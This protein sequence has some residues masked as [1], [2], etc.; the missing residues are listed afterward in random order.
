MS[1]ERIWFDT[2]QACERV[3]QHPVTVRKAAESGEL[4]GS[5]RTVGGRWRFHRDCV[6]AY[7]AGQPCAHAGA[8][9]LKAVGSG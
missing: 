4:H 5:Q 1:I 2:A 8:P 6:D 3:G 7:A 9:H